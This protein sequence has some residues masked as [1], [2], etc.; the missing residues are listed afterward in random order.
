MH[1]PDDHIHNQSRSQT[2]SIRHIWQQLAFTTF[3]NEY[4]K[5]R[6]FATDVQCLFLN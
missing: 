4:G 6:K 1:T 5:K 3:D 2:S